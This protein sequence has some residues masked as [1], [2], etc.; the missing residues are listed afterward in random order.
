M[1]RL[2]EEIVGRPEEPG[3]GFEIGHSY[4]VP[5]DQDTILDEQPVCPSIR[6]S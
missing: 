2:N 4:F 6:T 1:T 5:T 3:P